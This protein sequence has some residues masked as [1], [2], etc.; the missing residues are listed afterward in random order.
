MFL[1]RQFIRLST[2]HATRQYSGQS[3]TSCGLSLG[4][5]IGIILAGGVCYGVYEK[6]R[7][8]DDADYENMRKKQLNE[9]IELV[10]HNGANSATLN[11]QALKSTY[12]RNVA[13]TMNY[14]VM[15]K[16]IPPNY[17]SDD[18]I[19]NMILAKKYNLDFLPEKYH[20]QALFDRIIKIDNKLR[21]IPEKYRS[22]EVCDY[23]VSH[24]ELELWINGGF[25]A[26]YT[27]FPLQDNVMYITRPYNDVLMK[28]V[29]RDHNV[30]RYIRPALQTKEMWSYVVTK[31]YKLFEFMPKELQTEE[32]Q[33]E[34]VN[35]DPL[36]LLHCY[37]PSLKVCAI[38]Y[39]VDANIIDK[40]KDYKIKYTLMN[41]T[42]DTIER[43]I[44]DDN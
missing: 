11:Q 20:S 14:S 10:K 22:E 30:I 9:V 26:S 6:T 19:I 28:A 32:L 18:L 42:P 23:A 27:S 1:S 44:S 7:P 37:K 38:A 41:A 3:Q 29:K 8:Y 16:D 36:M 4:E 21:D 43:V 17:M 5:T 13:P 24:C 33:I 31:D 35:K 25:D 39:A 40:I 2:Q 15:I 12:D 34:M